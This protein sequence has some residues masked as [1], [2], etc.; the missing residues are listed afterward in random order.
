MSEEKRRLGDNQ[1]PI[2][3]GA[4]NLIKKIR[5]RLIV[6]KE[7]CIEAVLG[8]NKTIR[9]NASRYSMTNISDILGE[10]EPW[11]KVIEAKEN[12]VDIHAAPIKTHKLDIVAGAEHK[13]GQYIVDKENLND[14]VYQFLGEVGKKK[15]KI[16][17]V[18]PA[19]S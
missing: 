5:D 10:L 6:Q 2:T 7:S 17:F 15:I 8:R 1:N 14:K 3:D 11:N 12:G 9:D 18:H 4:I 13:F 19:G 16:G